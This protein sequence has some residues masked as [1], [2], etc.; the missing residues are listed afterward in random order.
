[1][2]YTANSRAVTPLG[3]PHTSEGG[4]GSGGGRPRC[5]SFG[6]LLW[7]SPRPSLPHVLLVHGVPGRQLS[8]AVGG[9]GGG[10]GW[11][12]RI[13]VDEHVDLSVVVPGV[14]GGRGGAGQ[15]AGP[16]R[17]YRAH[18]LPGYSAV[19]R[20]CRRRRGGGTVSQMASKRITHGFK[21][22]I[23]ISFPD[24]LS[25]KPSDKEARPVRRKQGKKFLISH[26]ET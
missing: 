19:R 6:G 4:C 21:C 13:L 5:L 2:R 3:Q 18:P 16:T 26:E 8:G 11:L 20:A 14:L 15:G 1:M 23:W 9:G 7:R 24:L 22:E 25:G 10:G 17:L 12:R